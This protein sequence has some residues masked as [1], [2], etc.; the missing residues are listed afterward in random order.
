MLKHGTAYVAQGLEEY[1]QQYRQRI[2][3]NLSRKA[4]DLGYELVK[5]GAVSPA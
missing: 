2:V 1:E 3:K 4:R 5:P